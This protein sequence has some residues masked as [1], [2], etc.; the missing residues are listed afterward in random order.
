MCISC[1]RRYPQCS[2]QVVHIDADFAHGSPILP[3]SGLRRYIRTALARVRAVLVPVLVP[4]TRVLVLMS[5][6]RPGNTVGLRFRESLSVPGAW[7]QRRL[8]RTN[9]EGLQLF[10]IQFT[11]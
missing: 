6:C 9:D 5:R 2:P 11:L 4:M 1:S 3:P 8:A 10:S 7:N